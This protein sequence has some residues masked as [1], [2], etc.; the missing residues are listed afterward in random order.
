MSQ[1]VADGRGE[2]MNWMIMSRRRKQTEVESGLSEGSG[3][4]LEW[5]KQLLGNF[6]IAQASTNFDVRFSDAVKIAATGHQQVQP[7]GQVE[8]FHRLSLCVG[9]V[10]DFD[11]TEAAGFQCFQERVQPLS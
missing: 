6:Q 1:S 7:L 2:S 11:A 9:T 10:V 3:C 8:V 4:L 5:L